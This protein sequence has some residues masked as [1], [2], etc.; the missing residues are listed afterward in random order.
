[1]YS[2][3][4]RK[5]VSGVFEFWYFKVIILNWFSTITATKSALFLTWRPILNSSWILCFPDGIKVKWDTKSLELGLLTSLCM[6][7]CVQL[8]WPD[9]DKIGTHCQ[10]LN[11][12]ITFQPWETN[13]ANQAVGFVKCQHLERA[14]S[15][16]QRVFW[17][18]PCSGRC[19][20]KSFMSLLNAICLFVHSFCWASE[21]R[22]LYSKHQNAFI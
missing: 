15:R 19:T 5:N 8:A 2:L 9:R 12:C 14:T 18:F 11:V 21:S 22:I 4:K 1:M 3:Y 6:L 17:S 13:R 20:R 16:F 7:A 10:C